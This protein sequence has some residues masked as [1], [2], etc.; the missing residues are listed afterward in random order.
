MHDDNRHAVGL[1]LSCMTSKY[2]VYIDQKVDNIN[3]KNKE[4]ENRIN[5]I[6]GSR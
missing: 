2:D 4:I 3:K 5:K 6:K 1:Q